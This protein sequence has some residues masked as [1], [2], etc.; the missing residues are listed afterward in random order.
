MPL[1]VIMV[2]LLG[3]AHANNAVLGMKP[4]MKDA[5][6]VWC[7]ARTWLYAMMKPFMSCQSAFRPAQVARVRKLCEP[8][9]CPQHGVPQPGT[10][11]SCTC[12]PPALRSSWARLMP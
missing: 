12:T 7:V 3:D 5:M 2:M 11:R 10:A 6:Y 9:T 1:V 4:G 8:M